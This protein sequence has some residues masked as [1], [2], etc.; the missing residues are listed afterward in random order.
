MADSH[1]IA[2]YFNRG[3]WR[4][5]VTAEFPDRW[6][7]DSYYAVRGFVVERTSLRTEDR[8]RTVPW[9]DQGYG[10]AFDVEPVPYWRPVSR[11]EFGD[12]VTFEVLRRVYVLARTNYQVNAVLNGSFD[13]DLS[14]W[15]HQGLGESLSAGWWWNLGKMRAQEGGGGAILPGQLG[16]RLFGGMYYRCS[17]TVGDHVAGPPADSLRFRL[18]RE[19]GV[20][21]DKSYEFSTSQDAIYTHV[22]QTPPGRIAEDLEYGVLLTPFPF[23]GYVDDIEVY[24]TVVFAQDQYGLNSFS[25][26]AE[27]ERYVLS[28]HDDPDAPTYW[29]HE[30]EVDAVGDGSPMLRLVKTIRP[31]DLLH[32][33]IGA[34]TA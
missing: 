10:S 8:I 20:Y 17:V 4:Y 19:D 18:Y 31:G 34:I 7:T 9:K 15:S 1:K 26:L 16:R 2:Y 11:Y 25:R 21:A 32:D 14:G 33:I 30:K 28:R 12:L 13:T 3:K 23:H 5:R 24:P 22:L 27:W 29:L 6:N